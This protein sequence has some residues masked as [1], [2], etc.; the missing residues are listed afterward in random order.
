MA[1]CWQVKLLGTMTPSDDVE[2]MEILK[3]RFDTFDQE[4]NANADKVSTVNNLCSQL[5]HNEHPNSEEAL[6]REQEVN[7][8]WD[9]LRRLADDKRQ[10]LKLHHEVNNWHMEVQE[11][12]TWIREKAKLIES[13]DELGNDLAGMTIMAPVFMLCVHCV[14]A[15]AVLLA[16]LM[17][18]GVRFQA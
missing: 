11:T 12:K 17:H 2:E 10:A 7:G 5:V 4:M 3:A 18:T 15:A 9:E 16:V 8:R 13:T 6:A 1:L 14:Y